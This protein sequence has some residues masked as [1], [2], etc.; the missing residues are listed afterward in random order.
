MAFVNIDSK[1]AEMQEGTNARMFFAPREFAD[2]E[3]Y[4][5]ERWLGELARRL[6]RTR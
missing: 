3:A 5:V 2:I 1:D 4:G 6:A